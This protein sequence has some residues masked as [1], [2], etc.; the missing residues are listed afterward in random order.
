VLCWLRACVLFYCWDQAYGTR[1]RRGEACRTGDGGV[2][3]E[4]D[5][6]VVHLKERDEREGRKE[7]LGGGGGVRQ[8]PSSHG[9]GG[10]AESPWV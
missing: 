4:N 3:E 8:V 7:V 2:E 1:Q 5:K 10:V 6:E 9:G